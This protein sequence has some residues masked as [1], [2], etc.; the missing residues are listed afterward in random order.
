LV[1]RCTFQ[2]TQRFGKLICFR[3][4]V[5]DWATP[6]LWGP[7]SEALC[8]YCSLEYRTIAKV[9]KPINPDFHAPPSEPIGISFN[10]SCYFSVWG[11]NLAIICNNRWNYTRFSD[12]KIILLWVVP[13]H[14]MSHSIRQWELLNLTSMAFCWTDHSWGIQSLCNRSGPS[15]TWNIL[16]VKTNWLIVSEEPFTI[17]APVNRDGP[18]KDA[19]SLL[20]QPDLVKR[21]LMDHIVLGLKLNL[22][23][24]G[25]F[26]ITTLGGRTVTVRRV[27]GKWPAGRRGVTSK[28]AL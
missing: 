16:R 1:H 11:T 15:R 22:N 21:L 2:R 9:Q 26:T 27:N 14:T 17:F 12:F 13:E 25:D 5:M 4:Q 20:A 23:L 3:P 19:Q 28:L 8:S 24:T 7:V 6:T 10:L 18:L